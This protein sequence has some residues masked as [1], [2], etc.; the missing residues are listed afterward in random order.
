MRWGYLFAVLTA[1]L[2]AHASLLSY[3]FA[4]TRT[5]GPIQSFSFSF[6]S[7]GFITGSGPFSFTPFNVTD[8]TNIYALTQS[9]S[10]FNVSFGN[11]CFGFGSTTGVTLQPNCGGALS[12]GSVILASFNPVPQ[13][14]GVFIPFFFQGQ[15]GL[16]DN[17]IGSFSG[18]FSLTIAD[19]AVPEPSGSFLGATGLA[20]IAWMMRRRA[21]PV[22][23]RGCAWSVSLRTSLQTSLSSKKL[24]S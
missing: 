6:T 24:T 18:T 13:S 9:L 17:Q 21:K 12:G 16:V 8:G 11:E 10:D 1:A 20:C 23:K 2:P 15:F 5:S 14:N 3:T 4:Y 19:A 7:P 22:L